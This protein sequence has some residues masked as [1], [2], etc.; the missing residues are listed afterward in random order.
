MDAIGE[1]YE[2]E[3]KLLEIRHA[4]ASRLKFL[5]QSVYDVLLS[6]PN[7]FTW[8]KSG[9]PSCPLCIG[10]DTLWHIMS[11][12]P[13]AQGDGRHNQVLWTVA[14]TV[15]AAIRASNFKLETKSIYFVKAGECPFSACKINS[16]LLS[17]PRDWQLRVDIG[18]QL[19]VPEQIA[20]TTLRQRSA[21]FLTTRKIF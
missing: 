8:G 14:D 6:P 13:R 5:V 17:T 11:V 2:E 9:I 12:C 15:D 19:K 3:N 7:L 16:C 1:L 10:K 18:K 20:P 21:H 4:N